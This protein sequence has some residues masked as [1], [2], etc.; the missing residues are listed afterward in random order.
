MGKTKLHPNRTVLNVAVR[1]FVDADS[2]NQFGLHDGRLLKN[3]KDLADALEHMSDDV[4]YHHANEH[5]NDFSTWVRDVLQEPELA[6]D[7]ISATN[8]QSAQLAVLKHIARKA[9]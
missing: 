7:L 3:V 9:F 2:N 8:Q 6:E 5:R 4:F 1:T